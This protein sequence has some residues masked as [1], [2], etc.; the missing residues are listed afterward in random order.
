MSIKLLPLFFVLVT[1][2]IFATPMTKEDYKACHD[3]V[4]GITFLKFK[5]LLSEAGRSR[6]EA[7][8]AQGKRKA[9]PFPFTYIEKK[10]C[11]SVQAELNNIFQIFSQQESACLSAKTLDDFGAIFADK[12]LGP[13][14]ELRNKIYENIYSPFEVESC[15]PAKSNIESTLTKL[16]DG[17]DGIA[18][19]ETSAVG[20][21]AIGTS[22]RDHCRE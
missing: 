4:A 6:V 19:C 21:Q 20:L 11:K 13:K 2:S 7:E 17:K 12:V 18:L 8:M 10:D 14:K 1:C 15:A 3:G 5:M 16:H 9:M 22:V